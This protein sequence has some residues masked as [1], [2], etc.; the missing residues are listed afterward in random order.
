MQTGVIVT[1]V[2]AFLIAAYEVSWIGESSLGVIL[3]AL[4]AIVGFQGVV[5]YS[6][7]GSKTSRNP[8]D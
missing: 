1:A 6:V 2:I 7:L 3:V 8:G 4:A 5:L